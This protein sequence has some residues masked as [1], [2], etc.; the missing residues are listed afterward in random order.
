MKPHLAA[1]ALMYVQFCM[2]KEAKRLL[3][4]KGRPGNIAGLP[5]DEKSGEDLPQEQKVS[6]QLPPF[7]SSASLLLQFCVSV[8]AAVSVSLASCFFNIPSHC[9][10]SRRWRPAASSPTWALRSELPPYTHHRYLP[11]PSQTPAVTAQLHVA[12]TA[13]TSI[14]ATLLIDL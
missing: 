4:T 6:T 12:A 9:C 10:R 8:C 14:R 1:T 11:D 3:A 13:A 5:Q 7:F 2:S